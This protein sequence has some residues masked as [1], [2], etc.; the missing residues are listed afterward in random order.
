MS[1]S[2]HFYMLIVRSFQLIYVKARSSINSFLLNTVKHFLMLLY[3]YDL[4]LHQNG[5]I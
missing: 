3:R 4:K 1:F 5:F 2:I